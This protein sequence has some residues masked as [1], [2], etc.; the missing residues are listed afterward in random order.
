M[1]KVI[2]ALCAQYE[3][4]MLIPLEKMELLKEDFSQQV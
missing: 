4:A 3:S 1:F 2:R